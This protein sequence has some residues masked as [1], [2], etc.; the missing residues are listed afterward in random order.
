MGSVMFN[1]FIIALLSSALKAKTVEIL[2][3]KWLQ[4]TNRCPG[5]IDKIVCTGHSTREK[6]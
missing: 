1:Y 2:V 4:K 3:N 5:E 6:L